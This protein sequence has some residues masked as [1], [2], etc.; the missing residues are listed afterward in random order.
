MGRT[1]SSSSSSSSKD[2]CDGVK[3]FKRFDCCLVDAPDRE[4]LVSINV[5]G[6]EFLIH[7][8]YRASVVTFADEDE[9]EE[10][11]ADALEEDALYSIK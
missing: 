8:P 10:A 11:E 2:F 3:K 5:N 1:F 4:D 9:E 6:T 7:F